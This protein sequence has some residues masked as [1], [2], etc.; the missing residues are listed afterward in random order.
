[1][2]GGI[3]SIIT[4]ILLTYYIVVT[5]MT[6]TFN[7]TYVETSQ[8]GLL[9]NPSNM[10]YEVFNITADQLQMYGLV[11]SSNLTI[12]SNLDAYVSGVF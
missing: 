2:P 5:V 9:S 11:Y 4:W 8:T 3:C 12:G 7:N 10:Q 1:M 6:H